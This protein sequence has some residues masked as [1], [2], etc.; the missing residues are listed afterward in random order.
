[1][2]ANGEIDVMSGLTA[3]PER[4]EQF[5]FSDYS[6]SSTQQKI[7]ARADDSNFFYE[8]YDT[9]NGT[10]VGMIVGVRTDEWEK[11]CIDHGFQSEIVT[12]NSYAELEE[13]L[14]NREIDLICGASV[15]DS[16]GTKIVGRFKKQPLYYA[17]TKG[18]P[19]LAVELN[20]AL[21][22]I[23]DNNPEFYTQMSE[24]YKMDGANAT[25]TFTREEEEYIRSGKQIYLV[26]NNDLAPISWYDKKSGEY[27][28]ISIDMAKE[29][30]AYSGLNIKPITG[31]EYDKMAQ[32]NPDIMGDSLALTADDTAWAARRN[33]MMTNHVVEGTIVLVHQIGKAADVTNPDTVIALPRDYYISYCLADVMK[34][35]S[36]V[37]FDT[38]EEC[39][40]AVNN[41]RADATFMNS[42]SAR[43]F[44]SM[45]RYT[46]LYVAAESG[47]S[48]NLSYGVYM[49][50]D[51][52]LLGI[53]DKSLLCIGEERTGQI[54]VQ[55]SQA[56]EKFSLAGLYYSNPMLLIVVIVAFCMMIGF[57][58]F[59]FLKAR[60]AVK[61]GEQEKTLARFMGYVC[62][63]NEVV[64]EI[65]LADFTA[66]SYSLDEHGGV[67]EEQLPYTQIHYQNAD[68]QIEPSDYKKL[69]K[70]LTEDSLDLMIAEGG[71]RYFECRSKGKD[72]AY[73]W[74][75]YTLQTIPKDK[76]HPRNFILFKKNIDSVKLEEEKNRQ[77]LEDALETARDASEAK[78][79]FL[80]RISHEIR[81]PLNAVIGYIAIAR[82]PDSD[83][84]KITHC[85]ENSD[86][87]SRHLLSILNDVL[88]MSSIESGKLKI[89]KEAFD[90]EELLHSMD[91]IYLEQARNK[92][93]DFKVEKE[94]LTTHWVLGDRMRVNQIL[95]NLVSNAIKFTEEDGAVT[96]RVTQMNS[97]DRRCRMKF[98][99][100]DTG[101]GM[102]EEYRNRLFKPFEQESAATAQ[103]FGGTGL[104]LSIAW[105]LVAMMG[106]SIEVKSKQGVGTT[107]TVLLSFEPC[108][109]DKQKQTQGAD[110]SRIRVLVVEDNQSDCEYVKTLLKQFGMKCD[111]VANGEKAIQRIKSRKGT[112]YEYRLCIMDW[113]MPGLDGIE[114][115][116]KIRTEVDEKIPIILTTAY[117]VSA[118]E[119]QAKE[120]GA[121]R[122]LPKPLFQSTLFN[123]M[124]DLFG[125]YT[126]EGKAELPQIDFK[127]MRILLAEDNE[128]N[129][130]IATEVL[131]RAGLLVDCVTN[132]KEALE[133]FEASEE[134]TYQIILMDIQMPV[135]DGY[136][137]TRR[138]RAGKHPQAKNIP[139]IATTANAFSED[140]AA[141]LA[142]GMNGHIAK[143]IDFKKLYEVL[144]KFSG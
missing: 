41:G 112:D 37:Y 40:D 74:Y 12:Y 81:T 65:N 78:G 62:A 28:G 105:N 94:N 20:D 82:Q 5:I 141:A 19:E 143:P 4:E 60:S 24:K 103:K 22:K 55:Y 71:K 126:S 61:M 25:A 139:I 131:R 29:I 127:G 70:N 54:V 111:M 123:V 15:S 128:M 14:K 53:L 101:I 134:N 138:I 34:N 124:V 135:M 130:E 8:S 119:E 90:L 16:A 92:K 68:E 33:I 51:T 56:E 129:L 80:S 125:Q 6:N 117:D 96:L 137:A 88:D 45:L 42:L 57:I 89:A 23:V 38:V 86:I 31:E 87:A 9:F 49:D 104:G 36:V 72:G 7:F 2:L 30:E 67:R 77:V 69:V 144:A 18:R 43:Y 79:N 122:I 102:S 66:M 83:S 140:V 132:G 120:A 17:V 35:K 58:V 100:S 97:D 13:A 116:R 11:Y 76:D 106:G 46:N 93:I 142:C 91:T 99:V 10:R 39:L 32:D 114:T 21:Q 48:E 113:K 47:Y 44:L 50:S 115:I 59:L 52:P 133:K 110:F 121:S 1:M 85:L 107:F 98:E 27:R 84:A 136:E 63:V 26:V 108:E 109:A 95:Y 64:M 3:S 75:S 118:V 73:H